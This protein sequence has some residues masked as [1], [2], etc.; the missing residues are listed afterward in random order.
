[1]GLIHKHPLFIQR[2]LQIS[3]KQL[4]C[5]HLHKLNTHIHVILTALR[6]WHE[7][8]GSW[9]M[10]ENSASNDWA[11]QQQSIK[12]L[13]R[14]WLKTDAQAIPAM[15]ETGENNL[16]C[17]GRD[18]Q[19]CTRASREK[20]LLTSNGRALTN[21]EQQRATEPLMAEH[22]R[23]WKRPARGCF[24]LQWMSGEREHFG[25][26]RSDL[27]GRVKGLLE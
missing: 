6:N 5:S 14:K 12:W 22:D 21:K 4:H 15:E 8:Y 23:R 3:D 26:L 11:A 1:M 20:T 16:T 24:E 19:H 10:A 25:W 2:T 7:G 27:S 9:E 18:W 17:E 13:L